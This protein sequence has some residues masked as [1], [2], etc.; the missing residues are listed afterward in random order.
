VES[1]GLADVATRIVC[2]SAT[3]CGAF[4]DMCMSSG[5][6]LRRSKDVGNGGHHHLSDLIA[7]AFM[8]LACNCVQG[9]EYEMGLM[10]VAFHATDSAAKVSRYRRGDIQTSKNRSRSKRVF[11][12]PIGYL[13]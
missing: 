12:H 8:R 7:S 13:H 11:F 5:A 3:P 10:E 9:K 6:G 1:L 2:E 4:G